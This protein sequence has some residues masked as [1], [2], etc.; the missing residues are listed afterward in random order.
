MLHQSACELTTTMALNAHNIVDETL[1]SGKHQ[2]EYL[3][4]LYFTS[5]LYAHGVALQFFMYVSVLHQ[6]QKMP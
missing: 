5:F 1:V 2:I 3:A 4:Y 6:S